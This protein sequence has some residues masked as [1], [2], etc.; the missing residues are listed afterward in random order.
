[1]LIN[2]HQREAFLQLI[3]AYR[4]LRNALQ[5]RDE[6]LIAA[7]RLENRK[8]GEIHVVIRGLAHMPSMT[9]LFHDAGMRFEYKVNEQ[10]RSSSA[11]PISRFLTQF[12][13]LPSLA[14]KPGRR[15]LQ[16]EIVRISTVLNLG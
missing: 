1:M 4:H 11:T 14:S 9:Q 8:R 6:S 10:N 16:D 2:G 13:D 5:L 3:Q 7:M 15:Y 12:R